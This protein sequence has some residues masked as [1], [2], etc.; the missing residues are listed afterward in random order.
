MRIPANQNG[1]TING[2]HTYRDYHMI[3]GNTD[4]VGEPQPYTKY[5][6]I[7]YGK[8]IDITEFYGEV[9]YINRELLIQIGALKDTK[10]WNQFMSEMYRDIQGKTVI[11]I[12][13]CDPDWY[14]TGRAFVED[15]SRNQELGRFTIRV[16][17]DPYKYA[18]V[19]SDEEWV[20]DTF[21]FDEGIIMNYKDLEVDGKRDVNVVG[22][23]K[24]IVPEIITS[25]EMT[26]EFKGKTYSLKRGSNKNYG[27]ILETGENTITFTG[28]GTVT[29]KYVRGCL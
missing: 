14:Y 4:I 20:W 17:A 18:T 13:D 26:A 6:E 7:P 15:F 3:I 19:A 24:R 9:T 29:I 12:L 1:A 23:D 2:K 27:I 28:Y 16:D 8:P 21:S 5:I 10:K 11:V 22:G 25:T